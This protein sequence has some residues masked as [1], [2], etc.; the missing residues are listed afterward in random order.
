[1]RWARS[2]RVGGGRYRRIADNCAGD[3]IDGGWSALEDDGGAGLC[4]GCF[5][6]DYEAAAGAI[7]GLSIAEPGGQGNAAGVFDGFIGEVEDNCGEASGLK[8]E[9]G[10][11]KGL[12]ETRPRLLFLCRTCCSGEAGFG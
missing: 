10:C 6:D 12:V 5:A 8:E 11:A 4:A 1:M 9:I 2:V 7:G 3:G